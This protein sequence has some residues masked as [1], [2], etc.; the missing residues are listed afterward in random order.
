MYFNM[1]CFFFILYT[2]KGKCNTL[3]SDT[4]CSHPV[5][6]PLVIPVNLCVAKWGYYK[7]EL[8]L[9]LTESDLKLV[10]F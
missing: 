3:L 10:S 4:F 7:N 5:P 1:Y 2:K 9:D 6:L 8:M